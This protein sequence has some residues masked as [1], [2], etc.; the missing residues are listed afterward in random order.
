M[1][2][3]AREDRHLGDRQVGVGGD[4]PQEGHETVGERLGGGALEQVGVVFEDGVDASGRAV[5]AVP[6][7]QV[8]GE[9]ELGGAEG[10]D[11]GPDGEAGQGEVGLG[12]VLQGE[13]H[14]EQRVPGEGPARSEVLHQPV[15]GHVLVGVGGQ[16]RLPDPVQQ[17]PEGGI[18]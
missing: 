18:A 14:L 4:R 12:R 7:G 17:F 10:D 15:E 6:L 5:G 11:L 2:F 1:A 8:E 9:V 3:A 16:V 13:Q